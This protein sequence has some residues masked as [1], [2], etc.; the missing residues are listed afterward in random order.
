MHRIFPVPFVPYYFAASA[1]TRVGR[2]DPSTVLDFVQEGGN[3]KYVLVELY[4]TICK[5]NITVAPERGP[6]MIN[7]T[8]ITL[9]QIVVHWRPLGLE[10]ARGF[11]TSYTV[12]AEPMDSRLRQAVSVNVGP[13]ERR[14]VLDSLN[15][16][17]VYVIIVS[18]STIAGES[19]ENERRVVGFGSGT[20]STTH[21]TGKLS[22]VDTQTSSLY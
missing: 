16:K 6:S 7:A 22:F 20:T 1:R 17:Q 21:I 11:I 12:R 9:T 10:H 5:I 14:A 4:L 2:G 8:R 19:S 15:P 3:L 13:N 18:A